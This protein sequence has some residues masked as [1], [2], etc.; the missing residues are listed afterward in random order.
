M[1]IC[2][3]CH[4]EYEAHSQRGI[5]RPCYNE[6]MR[7]YMLD[8]YYRRRT[9]AIERLGGRC[10]DCGTTEGLELDHHD[11]SLKSFDYGKALSGWSEERIQ[12]ELTKA[13]LRC[14]PCHLA[15]SILMGDIRTVPHGGGKAGKKN[16]KC[17][18]CSARRAEYSK[19][20]RLDHPRDR[21][22]R[23]E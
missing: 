22:K 14:K 6:K 20:Y 16:C 13:V 15:K 12:A 19:Q 9:A 1:P 5:C 8:R 10:V 17:D 2:N 4:Q 7:I 18:P 21:R 11:A 3:T 23:P